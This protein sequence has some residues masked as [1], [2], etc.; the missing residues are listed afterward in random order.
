MRPSATNTI[1]RP[2][3]GQWHGVHCLP[4]LPDKVGWQN[5]RLRRSWSPFSTER[6]WSISN[7]YP[8]VKLST[9]KFTMEFWNG[10]CNTFGGFG[11]NCTWKAYASHYVADIKQHVTRVLRE[12]LREAFADRFQQLYTRCQKCVVPKWLLWTPVKV[13]CL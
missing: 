7:L 8:R 5:P 10:C 3:Y 12:I 2:S 4:R 13:F 1:W 11:Q 9:R 6:V